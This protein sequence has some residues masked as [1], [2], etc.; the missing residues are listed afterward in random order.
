MAK[1]RLQVKSSPSAA[2]KASVKRSISPASPEDLA[3]ITI[4]G[5]ECTLVQIRATGDILLDVEFEN[6]KKANKSIPKDA[7][8]Q[9]RTAKQP[10]QSTRVIYRVRLETLK[11]NSKYFTHLLGSE[12]FAEGLS[13][14]K[15]L[16]NIEKAGQTASELPPN[17]LPRVQIRDEEDA[18]RTYGRE[19]V[20]RD[21]LQ[22]MHG[23]EHLT[24]IITLH[25][26]TVL[27]VMADR[28]DCLNSSSNS[29]NTTN[30]ISRYFHSNFKKFKY[31]ATFD[32]LHEEDLRQKIYIYHNTQQ[33]FA[34]EVAT[35]E[36]ILRGS[37]QWSPVEEENLATSAMWWDLPGGL[38]GICQ[39]PFYRA[40]ANFAQAELEHRH[41]RILLT[42]ARLQSQILQRYTSRDRQCQLGYADSPACDSFQLGEAIKFL[43]RKNLFTVT[44]PDDSDYVW[45]PAYHLGEIES[46]ISLLRQCPE[47]Q[48]N[49]NHHHC[50]IRSILIPRLECLERLMNQGAGM[51]RY[52]WQCLRERETWQVE[53]K[54]TQQAWDSYLLPKHI[55]FTNAPAPAY[56]INAGV[57]G[58]CYA[59]DYK[60]FFTK[61]WLA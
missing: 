5:E 51:N 18:T 19:I 10:I 44:S 57:E 42:I 12:A 29:A 1:D 49:G 61:C 60:G 30:P 34:F 8:R 48:I 37:S 22:I 27:V 21:L 16:S 46:L 24:K 56:S 32:R 52:N 3:T 2:G 54:A 25:Y 4:D 14:T 28:F 33:D 55:I 43:S 20:F 50:G 7:L 59:W 15:Q 47:Y 39:S 26:L 58:G 36:L 11:K 41:K 13:V 9:L 45:P 17:A 6:T 23:A 31:P 35:K 53:E 38:E 40:E